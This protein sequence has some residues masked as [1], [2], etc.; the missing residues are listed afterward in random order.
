MRFT[1]GIVL[2]AEHDDEPAEDFDGFGFAADRGAERAA[3]LLGLVLAADVEVEA[4]Q[5]LGMGADRHPVAR[6]E[7][8]RALDRGVVEVLVVGLLEQVVDHLL[9]LGDGL[10]VAV[11]VDGSGFAGG[12]EVL[13]ASVDRALKGGGLLVDDVVHLG[14][15]GLD[16]VG[17]E[18]EGVGFGDDRLD[19]V[20]ALDRD[21]AVVGQH[22]AQARLSRATHAAGGLGVHRVGVCRKVSAWR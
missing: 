17:D 5:A 11:V 13:V 21:E 10:F 9:K 2:E 4:G 7:V 15:Q 1:Q 20:V 19:E 22:E 8:D 16:A 6:R 18:G 3:E 12:V 14:R